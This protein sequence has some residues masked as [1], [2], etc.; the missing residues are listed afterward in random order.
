MSSVSVLVVRCSGMLVKKLGHPVPLSYFISELN[1]GRAQ[2]A[3]TKT[4][5]RFSSL[6][7]LVNGRSVDSLRSTKNCGSER[8]CFHSASLFC[9][10]AVLL[11]TLA[12]LASS[13]VQSRWIAAM[14]LVFAASAAA[15]ETARRLAPA[16]S[17]ATPIRNHRLCMVL[18]PYPWT[19]VKPKKTA[20]YLP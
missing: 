9:R 6:S 20:N 1:S 8:V 7:G 17:A 13:A 10:G 2:P 18:P 3:Q 4:P 11:A 12:S 14:D 19:I 5:A 15:A 16:L